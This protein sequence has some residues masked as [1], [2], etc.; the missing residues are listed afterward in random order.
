MDGNI[1]FIMMLA[2]FLFLAYVIL[3]ILADLLVLLWPIN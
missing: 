1:F 3:Y 2:Y